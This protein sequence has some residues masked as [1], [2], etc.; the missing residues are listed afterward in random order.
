MFSVPAALISP[1]T[2]QIFDVPIS[3]PTMMGIGIKH[4]SFWCVERFGGLRMIGGRTALASASA[5]GYC[6][7][8]RDPAW[9]WPC[10]F[11]CIDS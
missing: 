4:V 11:C 6:S 5:P 3:S 8:R 1:T 10:P 9:R 7:A 2:A